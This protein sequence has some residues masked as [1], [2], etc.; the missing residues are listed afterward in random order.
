M[1]FAIAVDA[2]MVIRN[3]SFSG[4]QQSTGIVDADNSI[5]D[6]TDISVS[7]SSGESKM[8]STFYF[9]L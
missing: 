7:N 6:F 2:E 4:F 9:L 1:T 5:L 8:T 3:C